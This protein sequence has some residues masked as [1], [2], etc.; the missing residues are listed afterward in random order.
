M[1]KYIK[2][3]LIVLECLNIVMLMQ[4]NMNIKKKKKK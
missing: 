4:K 2:N 3:Y 1:K